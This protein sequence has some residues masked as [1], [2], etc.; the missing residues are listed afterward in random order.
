MLA[1]RET[2]RL[3]SKA[4][5]PRPCGA[6]TPMKT[7]RRQFLLSALA[8][9][10]GATGAIHARAES[11]P[12]RPVRIVVGFPAGG[13]VDI[14]ARITA[15]CLAER[16]GQPFIVEN[17]PGA[18]GNIGTDSV[19]RAAPD[20]YTLLMCGPV[21]TINTSLYEN[22]PFDFSTDI[23]PVAG[24]IRVPLVMVVNPSLPVRTVAEFVEYAKERPGKVNMASGGNGTPHHV[25][26]ELFKLLTGVDMQHIPYR[27]SAP[28]LADLVGG[29]VQVMFDPI[30]S[31]M[32]YVNSGRLR[33][34]AVTTLQRATMWPDLPTVN[35]RVPGYEAYSWYGVG[36]P[37]YTPTAIIALLNRELNAGLA[38]AKTRSRLE[39]IGGAG[40]AG[41]SQDFGRLI[42]TETEK[43]R[44]VIQVAHIRLD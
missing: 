22:L 16:L 35:E 33:A 14:V 40:L 4:N 43:W 3:V 42:A 12:S 19:V 37:R 11:Y 31:S 32:E 26:G 8:A 17:R 41:S 36:A 29:Q 15:Q 6:E 27:G 1:A 21:N 18:G 23:A 2:S 5:D 38:E 9:G 7:T 30:P 25:A 34:L 39:S 13:P 44:R 24:V 28:A 10:A 20:G